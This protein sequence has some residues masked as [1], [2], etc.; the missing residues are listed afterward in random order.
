M[1]LK[2]KHMQPVVL[3]N[4]LICSYCRTPSTERHHQSE[5]ESTKDLNCPLCF[6]PSPCSLPYFPTS[7]DNM[8]LKVLGL[9][10]IPL[11]DKYLT[12]P[13]PSPWASVFSASS[14]STARSVE[15]CGEAPGRQRGLC[16]LPALTWD[17]VVTGDSSVLTC[18]LFRFQVSLNTNE[19]S[20]SLA[21][22]CVVC[23]P[24]YWKIY[25]I[26]FFF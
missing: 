5:S 18:I 13:T 6:F 4:W 11:W 1:T 2:L 7:D 21:T 26:F 9:N 16:E 23:L 17:V 10:W 22:P 3:H 12:L 20:I 8:S 19:K 14:S 24:F 25:R 15:V